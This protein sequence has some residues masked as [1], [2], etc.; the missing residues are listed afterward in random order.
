MIDVIVKGLNE[1]LAANYIGKGWFI[2]RQFEEDTSFNAIKN[3]IVEIYY[4]TYNVNYPIFKK[5]YP[6]NKTTSQYNNDD[7]LYS[8]TMEM[9]FSSLSELEDRIKGF[10]E[11][12]KKVMANPKIRDSYIKLDKWFRENNGME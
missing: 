4:H 7:K 9:I 10:D 5:I 1:W 2:G 11:D 12:A 6:V 3:K 8:T